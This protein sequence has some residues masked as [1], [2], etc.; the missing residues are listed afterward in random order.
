MVLLGIAVNSVSRQVF[1]FDGAIIGSCP[2]TANVWIAYYGRI[3]FRNGKADVFFLR[4]RASEDRD[5]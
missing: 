1:I 3:C 5:R 2:Q 4:T